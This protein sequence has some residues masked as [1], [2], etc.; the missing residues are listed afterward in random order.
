VPGSVSI[1][2]NNSE[3]GT[4]GIDLIGFY[5][6]FYSSG[7]IDF[8][9][10]RTNKTSRTVSGTV[11]FL[12]FSVFNVS[13]LMNFSFDPIIRLI[14]NGWSGNQE[15]FIPISSVNSQLN[16]ILIMSVDEKVNNPFS[17]YPNPVNDYLNIHTTD[18][19]KIKHI[20]LTD[21]AGKIVK[22]IIS[23][24]KSDSEK[25]RCNELAG[26]FYFLTLYTST[27]KYTSKFE[28]IK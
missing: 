1:D 4:P 22:E 28:I 8:G 2:F 14:R 11:A 9:M 15:V 16:A 19:S 5:K 25:V 23:L 6:D 7:Y 17:V 12:N 13:G 18:G 24:D 3:L 10:V 27:G 20:V 21:L 26:G